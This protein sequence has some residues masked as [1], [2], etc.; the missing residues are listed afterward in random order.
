MIEELIEDVSTGRELVKRI[1]NGFSIGE[2]ELIKDS[3]T[4]SLL[5]NGESEI[6]IRPIK[7]KMVRDSMEII[8]LWGVCFNKFLD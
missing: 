8:W 3:N 7:D 6:E 1:N 5:K 2:F 4:I